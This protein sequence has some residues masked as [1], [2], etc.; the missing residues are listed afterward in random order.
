M[1]QLL[2]SIPLNL[3]LVAELALQPSYTPGSVA[4]LTA[5]S[6]AMACP[7]LT[8]GDDSNRTTRRS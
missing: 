6:D 3:R 4:S 2:I 7:N 1:A 8:K 5:T